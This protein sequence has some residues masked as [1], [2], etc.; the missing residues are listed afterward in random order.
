VHIS[1]VKDLQAGPASVH[2]R[3]LAKRGQVDSPQEMTS[4][5]AK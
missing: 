5:I 3:F 4:Y 1:V 2:F